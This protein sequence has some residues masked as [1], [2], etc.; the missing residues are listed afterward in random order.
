[1]QV[2]LLHWVLVERPLAVARRAEPLERVEVSCRVLLG[3]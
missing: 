2:G 1:L 3:A